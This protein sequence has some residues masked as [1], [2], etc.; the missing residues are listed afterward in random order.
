[1]YQYDVTVGITRSEV[2]FLNCHLGWILGEYMDLWFIFRHFWNPKNGEVYTDANLFSPMYLTMFEENWMS[3]RS[4]W[5]KLWKVNMTISFLT[6]T[7]TESSPNVAAEFNIFK[8]Y[9]HLWPVFDMPS[10]DCF[11]SFFLSSCLLHICHHQNQD[12]T[13]GS[14][15]LYRCLRWQTQFTDSAPLCHWSFPKV[16][17]LV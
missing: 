15:E 11:S 12:S 8:A 6:N 17:P 2:I 9:R 7:G 1:M 5:I 16:A 10:S 13:P 3:L 4:S 14:A